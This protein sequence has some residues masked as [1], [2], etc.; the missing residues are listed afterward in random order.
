MG[1]GP[2]KE[3]AGKLL[4][5]AAIEGKL[6]LYISAEYRSESERLDRHPVVLPP[7]VLAR[8]IPVRETLPDHPVRN[9]LRIACADLNI[10]KLLGSG[11]LL[12]RAEEFTAW[13]K[14]ER[15]KGKWPSQH[16]RRREGRPSKQSAALRKAALA[17][18][19]E[20]N[21]SIAEVH[22]RLVSS[23]RTDVPSAD[24]IRRM[25]DR[26]YRE[27]GDPKLRR[28]KRP[29]RKF[30]KSASVTQNSPLDVKKDSLSELN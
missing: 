12:V 24:T 16:L 5:R 11:I 4:R 20:E 18:I 26:L 13:Y 28:M 1:F 14:A 25:M 15:V 29:R 8:M 17:V 21:T 2:W 6:A 9:S 3:E 30:S 10:F 19:D 22:R 27:T 23:E 7:S